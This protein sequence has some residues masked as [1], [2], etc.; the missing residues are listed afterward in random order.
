MFTGVSIIPNICYDVRAWSTSAYQAKKKS[1][2]VSR[3]VKS[4]NTIQYII[5]FTYL[6][7]TIILHIE[8]SIWYAKKQQ[9]TVCHSLFDILGPDCLVA[10]I[11]RVKSAQAQRYHTGEQVRDHC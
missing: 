9:W 3:A 8:L 4:A 11:G 6:Q 7:E 5:H 10:G 1:V 2:N